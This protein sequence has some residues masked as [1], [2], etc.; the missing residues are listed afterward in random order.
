MRPAGKAFALTDDIYWLEGKG[1]FFTI[2]SPPRKNDGDRL[3]VAARACGDL[4]PT[5]LPGRPSIP[6]PFCRRLVYPDPKTN[7]PT[8]FTSRSK[9]LDFHFQFDKIIIREE[10]GYLIREV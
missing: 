6:Q 5:G 8:L 2:A 7:K 1:E 10:D 9:D 4:H 3:L